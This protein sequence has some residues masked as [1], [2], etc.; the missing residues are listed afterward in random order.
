MTND[1]V[2]QN[3]GFYLLSDE[4][5]NESYHNVIQWILKSNLNNLKKKSGLEHLTLVINSQGGD[6][7]SCFGIVDMMTSSPLPIHTIGMGEVMS[8]GLMILMAGQKGNRIIT[9]NTTIM[10]H[11]FI[12]TDI[13]AKAYEFEAIKKDFELTKSKYVNHYIKYTG[14]DYNVLIEKLLTTHDSFLDPDEA[15]FLG[16]CDYIKPFQF[17]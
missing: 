15:V 12:K 11:Q 6:L 7:N 3:F 4:I 8:A 9:P 1:E 5:N 14:L 16:I 10:S 2:L 17:H 13:N